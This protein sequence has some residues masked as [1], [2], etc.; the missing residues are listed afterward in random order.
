MKK[1]IVLLHIFL[2]MVTLAFGQ[3]SSPF[4]Y[5]L[6]KN[7]NV[8]LTGSNAA[9]L[10][11]YNDSNVVKGDVRFSYDS[12]N[13]EPNNNYASATTWGAEVESFY[14]LSKSIMV[15]GSMAF[16]NTETGKQT[17]SALIN[18]DDIKPFDILTEIPGNTSLQR[19]DVTGALGWNVWK[20]MSIGANVNY[21]TATYSRTK[22]LR[23]A[24]AFMNLKANAGVFADLKG[25]ALGAT[26]LYRRNSE[27][28]IFK[29]YG[30]N[31]IVY[32]SLIE[33]ANGIGISE[34]YNGNGFTDQTEQPLFSEYKGVTAQI[35]VPIG[36]KLSVF[37]D[38]SYAHRKG[39][40]GKESQYTLVHSRHESDCYGINGRISYETEKS[41]HWLKVN[42]N[43]EN[44][45]NSRMNYL[46][47]TNNGVTKYS[48]FDP[49]KTA[50]KV[51]SYGNISYTTYFC[52][53]NKGLFAWNINSGALFNWRKQTAYLYPQQVTK[54][55]IQWAP[56]IGVTRNILFRNTSMFTAEVSFI[57]LLNNE[58]ENTEY[59]LFRKNEFIADIMARYEFP[60]RKVRGL[61]ANI[62]I[63]YSTHNN[64]INT[65]IGVTY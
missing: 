57:G 30:T 8:W 5:S 51:R 16:H 65:T 43:T 31:D 22:D 28:L 17:G 11:T 15:F 46:R 29:T 1:K 45:V 58:P 36:K 12:D 50:N 49:I 34:T 55:S 53:Q 48:Y 52:P 3:H 24:N 4:D 44:L 23:H 38:F 60:I 18:T 9:A 37:A 33:Y 32:T 6:L 41:L 47:E 20:R 63:K 27:S 59:K 62:G 39:Y 64:M 2:A 14:R 35:A 56:Y 19:I 61:R 26:F 13:A 10:T 21:T 40:Y 42:I 25:I 54:A 7:R